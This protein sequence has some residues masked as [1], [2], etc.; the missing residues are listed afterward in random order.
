MT[1]A[2][3]LSSGNEELINTQY[4]GTYPD[5]LVP[6]SMTV[7]YLQP[8]ANTS[9]GVQTSAVSFAF[10]ANA[11]GGSLTVTNYP[12]AVA[13]YV[14]RYTVNG[15]GL[16]TS[17]TT[18]T[19]AVLTYAATP[20][21][22]D[23]VWD[24]TG[25]R[26]DASGQGKAEMW[27]GVFGLS[28]AQICLPTKLWPDT[29]VDKTLPAHR[30]AYGAGA[31][32]TMM[33]DHWVNLPSF[34]QK[35]PAYEHMAL[36]YN[37]V[38]LPVSERTDLGTTSYTYDASWRLTG[39]TE[40]DAAGNVL[41]S[42]ALS[43]F[44]APA[45]EVPGTMTVVG[46]DG[47][48]ITSSLTMMPSASDGTTTFSASQQI[49]N[50]TVV[51]QFALTVDGDGNVLQL[52]DLV[53]G[54][55]ESAT[56][57]QSYAGFVAS[58][59]QG[60]LAGQT[61]FTAG[62][63]Q[64]YQNSPYYAAAS[65]D[66]QNLGDA[67][68]YDLI[69]SPQLARQLAGRN[70]GGASGQQSLNPFANALADQENLSGVRSRME[71]GLRE[72]DE[73][74]ILCR[75][76]RDAGRGHYERHVQFAEQRLAACD[77]QEH[78]H[79][80]TPAR[81]AEVGVVAKRSIRRL[82]YL[83]AALHGA[84]RGGGIFVA[85][86][87]TRHLSEGRNAEALGLAQSF[88]WTNDGL[89]PQVAPAA[90]A[91]DMATQA[92]V[93]STLNLTDQLPPYVRLTGATPSFLPSTSFPAMMPA[94]VPCNGTSDPTMPG[95]EAMSWVT[96]TAGSVAAVAKVP[97]GCDPD[98]HAGLPY[99]GNSSWRVS[100]P[101]GPAPYN[102]VDSN[103]WTQLTFGQ[104]GANGAY[105]LSSVARMVDTGSG[106]PSAFPLLTYSYDAIGNLAGA[107]RTVYTDQGS[108]ADSWTFSGAGA[109][110][111]TAAGDTYRIEITVQQYGES[112][113]TT[114]TVDT[115]RHNP[116]DPAGGT[117][118]A[119]GFSVFLSGTNGAP[120]AYY[121]ASPGANIFEWET[122]T[123]NSKGAYELSGPD[124]DFEITRS[125]GTNNVVSVVATEKNEGSIAAYQLLAG[126]AKFGPM[127]ADAL[128]AT[129]GVESYGYGA[130]GSDGVTGCDG[131]GNIVLAS[132]TSITEE[133]AQA[134][135]TYDALNRLSQARVSQTGGQNHVVTWSWDSSG[136]LTAEA[137]TEQGSPAGSL[138]DRVEH[139]EPY[140]RALATVLHDGRRDGYGN[141]D[142]G[143]VR[144][145]HHVD[146][147]R[148][149]RPKA[150]G[151]VE[152][153]LPDGTIVPVCADGE[154]PPRSDLVD[155]KGRS[156]SS[157]LAAKHGGAM[158]TVG[159]VSA[160]YGS[161]QLPG[162]PT[163]ETATH[164]GVSNPPSLLC[165]STLIRFW[166]HDERRL[167]YVC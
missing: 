15:Y 149:H 114:S 152:V 41:E 42:T 125:V 143:C 109:V 65:W 61:V 93:D 38:G 127:T 52:G 85:C 20:S 146:D 119:E 81:S 66:T 92:L 76:R 43:N 48:P 151:D 71:W 142:S 160:A 37:A 32:G 98:K 126:G 67:F 87:S 106:S 154:P 132:V 21:Q 51:Q 23:T 1:S 3:N 45:P 34:A 77:R 25:Q 82:L 79:T 117:E 80:S 10:A 110:L 75:E 24:L 166:A 30:W 135:F 18:P 120:D 31:D 91:Y 111:T 124:E 130:C 153:S 100:N 157:S 90:I 78:V 101:G 54:E 83:A 69:Q 89:R 16:P 105:L 137:E 64:S 6:A 116:G 150:S 158:R 156:T 107:T 9:G 122:V 72:H 165:S 49:G 96:S 70:A 134:V 161:T 26:T 129:V 53:T 123:A 159:T 155:A 59:I 19:G 39:V 128:E 95:G 133:Q 33:T 4:S 115:Y 74:V 57:Q 7:S 47:T 28:Q 163:S 17:N 8:G 55:A 50:G 44:L 73:H 112:G 13:S 35:A 60:T 103:S 121:F 104:P 86:S 167:R 88:L 144:L 136:R 63:A 108:A 148:D 94:F 22:A 5:S 141:H 2:F 58:S 46:L 68:S 27:Y 11:S 147:G 145:F 138:L 113:A 140:G 102:L 36:T 131:T 14:D 164:P 84:F 62:L 118:T 40:A 97:F 99:F 12:D 162:L 56:Y 29:A 139:A